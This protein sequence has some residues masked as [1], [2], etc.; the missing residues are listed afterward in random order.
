VEGSDRE[1]GEVE[2]Y[3][4]EAARKSD[5]SA[6]TSTRKRPAS[7]SGHRG[8]NPANKSK[9]P[10]FV[11]DYVLITYGTGIV[12]GVPGHDQRDWDFAT[13]FG[14]PSSR[15]SRAATSPRRPSP[16]R[17]TPASW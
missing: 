14:C 10:I 6:R 15:S 12:M 17:T 16:S 2:A 11:S 3:M 7:A 8:V 5:L 13:K 1:L 9:I 4:D